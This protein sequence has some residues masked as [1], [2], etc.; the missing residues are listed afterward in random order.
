[1]DTISIKGLD[2][3]KLV[4]FIW[5]NT[6]ELEYNKEKCQY[7]VEGF[8]YEKLKIIM[9]ALGPNEDFYLGNFCGKVLKIRF[10]CDKHGA[11]VDPWLYDRNHPNDDGQKLKDLVDKF[12]HLSTSPPPTFSI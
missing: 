11:M 1:M 2:R 8:N 12:K 10:T 5:D 9:N 6:K 7:T 4:K 3:V